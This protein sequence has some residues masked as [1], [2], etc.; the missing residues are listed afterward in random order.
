V[1][2]VYS[3][4]GRGETALVYIHGGLADRSFFENQLEH[5]RGAH[6]VVAV[7]LAGHGESG[8]NRTTWGLHQFAA[9]VRSVADAEGL[10]RM[11]LFGNSLGGPVAIEAAL[12]MP[13]RVLGVVGIDTF[14]D[15]GEPRTPE[16][17]RQFAEAMRSRAEALKSDYPGT[18]KTML[19][20]LFH[21]DADP[22]IVARAEERMLATSP[23]VAYSM[24]VSLV[25]DDLPRAAR[26][27]RAPLRAINGDLYP[28]DVAA[29]R[30]VKPD[31]EAVIMHHTGHYP[32]LEKPVEF[33]SHAASIVAR[34]EQR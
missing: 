33:N 29:I 23:A 25:D 30:T 22:A 6:R 3:A 26:R 27:L 15:L 28:T 11:V 4:A 8:A 17:A 9:D 19:K 34:L 7:D 2:V 31:F 21:V 10:K 13:D 14:Q 5:F 16:R 1:K 12:L 18:V 20:M 32:M 24:L